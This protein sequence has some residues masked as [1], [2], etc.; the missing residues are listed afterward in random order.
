[1]KIGDVAYVKKDDGWEYIAYEVIG[2]T[3][4][5]YVVVPAYRGGYKEATWWIEKNSK[6]LAK[7]G[8]GY[9]VGTKREAELLRW[10]HNNRRKISQ[11]LSDRE[12]S[13]TLLTIAR[14][15][16]YPNPFVE[17]Q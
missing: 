6:K 12:G 4:R 3:S 14:M 16:N 17:E 2:E 11:L 7:S 9:S 8:A 10:D 13:E 5:S 15:L 1:M